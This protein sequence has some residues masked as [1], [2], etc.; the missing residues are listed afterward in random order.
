MVSR[1]QIDKTR[2]GKNSE[3]QTLFKMDSRAR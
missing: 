3:E 1:T 2:K